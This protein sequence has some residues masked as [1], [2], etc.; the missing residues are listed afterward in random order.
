MKRRLLQ[1]FVR[2]GVKMSHKTM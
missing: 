2:V 1:K